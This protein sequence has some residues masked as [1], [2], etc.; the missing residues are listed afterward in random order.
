[1]PVHKSP[2]HK[3]STKYAV[4]LSNG[5][6]TATR[7]KASYEH[8]VLSPVDIHANGLTNDASLQNDSN[9]V[10][11]SLTEMASVIIN[12]ARKEEEYKELRRDW[13]CVALVLD[14]VFFYSYVIAIA[15]SLAFLF[16]RPE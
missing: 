4:V 3:Y 13:N 1:M 9:K 6:S 10:S 12:N 15:L 11:V 7:R 16:P 8:D 2:A 14:R 5:N